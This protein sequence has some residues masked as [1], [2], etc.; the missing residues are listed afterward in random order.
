[1]LTLIVI[2]SGGLIK[3]LSHFASAYDARVGNLQHARRAFR[4]TVLPC[5]KI[6]RISAGPKKTPSRFLCTP[7]ELANVTAACESRKMNS[8][9]ERAPSIP[10]RDLILDEAE[11]LIALKGVYGFTLKDVVVPLGVQVSSIYKH[12]GS[13]DDLLV[14][15]SRRFIRRLSQQ[16]YYPPEALAQPMATLHQIVLEFAR[17]H[18]SHAAYVRLSL[19]DFATPEG[20]VDYIR[21]AAGG[22]FRSNLSREPLAPVHRRLRR[23]LAAGQCL[24]E[25]RA[26]SA[27]DFFRLIKSSLL[28]RLVFPDDLLVGPMRT[29]AVIRSVESWL[30][31]IAFRYTALKFDGTD[32]P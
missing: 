2:S 25:F 24:G 5:S 15:L 10:T 32:P 12:Y 16:L 19:V 21:L 9:G 17:F 11:R 27:I 6:Y 4:D 28:I 7:K 13:R 14:A 23:L 30:W 18:I 20:G 31:D 1:M 26:V 3:A 22:P 29:E 8:L